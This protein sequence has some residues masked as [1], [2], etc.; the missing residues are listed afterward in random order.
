M[1]LSHRQTSHIVFPTKI[2]DV[3]VGSDSIIADLADGID[4][5]IK[6]KSLSAGFDYFEES[7][8]TIITEDHSIYPFVIKYEEYPEIINYH[9]AGENTRSDALFSSLSINEPAMQSCGQKVLDQG[10]VLRNYGVINN[11]MSFSLQGIFVHEDVMMFSIAVDNMSK[12]DY[13]IDFIKNYV[14]NKKT[15]K[16]ISTIIIILLILAMVIPS[17]TYLLK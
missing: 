1:D 11:K 14:I 6:C 17:L 3:T 5:I 4:N 8:L 2:L 13:E 10:C 16:M 12:I 7:S 9:L 15:T